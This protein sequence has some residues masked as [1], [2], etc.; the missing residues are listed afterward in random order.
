MRYHLLAVAAGVM[1]GL[2]LAQ[3]FLEGVNI[4]PSDDADIFSDDVVGS[5]QE[6]ADQDL[7]AFNDVAIFPPSEA[8]SD[9]DLYL[10]PLLLAA[11]TC[12]GRVNDDEDGY[13]SGKL[14]ERDSP[15]MCYSQDPKA[16]DSEV[17][18]WFQKLPTFLR[19]GDNPV[20]EPDPELEE[21]RRFLENR[22]GNPDKCS[23]PYK[24]NLCC[25]GDLYGNLGPVYD[26][27][28]VPIIYLRVEDC[29]KS[30][31]MALK[32]FISFSRERRGV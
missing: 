11:S 31:Y 23:P 9:S 3:N 4:I 8:Y 26:A 6:L 21:T 22:V 19:G 2:S 13:L 1:L 14:R 30:M 17:E 25:N 10:D 24:F 5:S 28:S 7:F 16:K 27:S 20:P 32:G 12:D 29:Y 15:S 18:G